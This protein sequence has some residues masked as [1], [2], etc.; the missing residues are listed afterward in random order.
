MD[1]PQARREGASPNEVA[2]RVVAPTG[3][4]T[5]SDDDQLDAISKRLKRAYGQ[6]GGVIRL[7]DEGATCEKVVIQMAAVS[8]ALNAAAFTLISAGLK[9]CLIDPGTDSGPATE[10]FEKLFLSLA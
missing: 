2:E 3:A 6:F 9:E 8:K 10:K 7:L 5:L 4:R 1:A